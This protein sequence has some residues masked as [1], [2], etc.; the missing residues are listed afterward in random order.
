MASAVGI[1]VSQLLLLAAIKCWQV[2]HQH[3]QK[4]A[5]NM[6]VNASV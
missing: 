3:R 2:G 4:P 6:T 5:V 1:L